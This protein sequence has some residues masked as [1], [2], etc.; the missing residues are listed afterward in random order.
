MDRLT[1]EQLLAD[2]IGTGEVIRIVYHGGSR[3]GAV[4]EVCPMAV[5][6][7]ELR[8]HDLAAGIAKVF[9]L[10]KLEITDAPVTPQDGDA[11]TV[12]EAVTP[13]ISELQALGWHVAL[14][15]DVAGLHPYFKNGKP[16]KTASVTLS[17]AEYVVDFLVDID[18]GGKWVEREERRKSRAPYHVSSNTLATRSFASLWKAAALFLEEARRAAPSQKREEGESK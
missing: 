15:R 17:F 8:A 2:A 3:P 7:D 9:L 1:L 14:T 11:H 16:R 6:G 13:R 12:E 4:R 5:V 18:D 10:S